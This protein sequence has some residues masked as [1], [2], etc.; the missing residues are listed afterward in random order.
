M[1]LQERFFT[2]FPGNTAQRHSEWER[3]HKAYTGP[4]RHYHN[5][6]HL[7]Q[8]F[9]E[10]GHYPEPIAQP[11]ALD[12]AIFYHDLVY[13]P[14]RK[15][16]E[17]ASARLAATALQAIEPAQPEQY[18][19]T[20]LPIP[21]ITRWITATKDHRIPAGHTDPDLAV[22]LDIDLCILG[23]SEAEYAT[24]AAN[25]R[26]EYSI[27]PDLLYYPAR[28][29]A[30]RTFLERDNIYRTAFFRA[31]YEAQARKNIRNEIS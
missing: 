12:I 6:S 7:Q 9:T 18:K 20:T 8:M 15:D 16:N 31:K 1:N 13:N 10:L 30:M 24:Y 14:L 4:K 29:K 5:L 19:N 21:K 27:Y 23:S 17:A 11:E 25:V 28:K 3:I 26:R 22:L 2:V